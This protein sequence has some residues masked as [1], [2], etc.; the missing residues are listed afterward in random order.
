MQPQTAHHVRKEQERQK[1]TFDAKV[2]ERYFS[3]NDSVFV[4]NYHPSG[5]KWVITDVLGNRSYQV[6]ITDGHI[7]RK[8]L[9][10]IRQW[11]SAT[12]EPTSVDDFLPDSTQEDNAPPN[13]EPFA[14]RKSARE[15]RQPERLM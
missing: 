5:P 3:V 10:Q 9:D 13:A 15:R 11:T 1:E 4:R 2:K 6:S 7:V 14:P 12:Q 8:H